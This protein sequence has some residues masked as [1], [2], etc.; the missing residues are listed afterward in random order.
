MCH[1]G[2]PKVPFLLLLLKDEADNGAHEE[3]VDHRAHQE[4][5]VDSK[6][7]IPSKP[8]RYIQIFSTM[9]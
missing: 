6:D 3:L 7:T 4:E 9:Q 1:V 5:E 2:L 8:A